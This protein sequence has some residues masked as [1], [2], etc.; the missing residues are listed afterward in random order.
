MP[1]II[2]I[3]EYNLQIRYVDLLHTMNRLCVLIKMILQYI[4]YCAQFQPFCQHDI[5]VYTSLNLICE[6]LV[7][8]PCV[9]PCKL[10]YVHR[11]V[12][13]CL[14]QIPNFSMFAWALPHFPWFCLL[15]I[16]SLYFAAFRFN[17][18]RSC[19]PPVLMV[20]PMFYCQFWPHEWIQAQKI[21]LL[22]RWCSYC[23]N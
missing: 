1:Y 19:P 9:P 2:T 14:P 5:H 6:F 18:M 12:I 17:C 3:M 8:V 20:S 16:F 21:C 13:I 15:P 10:R 22:W 7:F 4:P 23:C 11:N